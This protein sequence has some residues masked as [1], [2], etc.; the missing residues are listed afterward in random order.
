MK[1]MAYRSSRRNFIRTYSW[2][3]G[4]GWPQRWQ[5]GKSKSCACATRAT[6]I[7]QQPGQ[8]PFVLPVH[9]AILPWPGIERL[10]GRIRV[11]YQFTFGS[12]MSSVAGC[13]TTV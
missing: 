13:G 3:F 7:R 11:V 2:P 6:P 9:A 4:I 1:Q 8:V 12:P 5:S 10:Y